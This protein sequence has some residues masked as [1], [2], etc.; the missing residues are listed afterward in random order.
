MEWIYDFIEFDESL[1]N[2][3]GLLWDKKSVII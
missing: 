1:I 2:Q 3:T